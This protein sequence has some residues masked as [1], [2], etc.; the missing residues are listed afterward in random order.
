MLGVARSGGF[1][2]FIPSGTH[3]HVPG[4]TPRELRETSNP[5]QV[6]PVVA[7]LGVALGSHFVANV[8]Q[9]A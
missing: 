8:Y 2:A 7:T 1:M 6:E 3:L 5:T 4:K 9:A